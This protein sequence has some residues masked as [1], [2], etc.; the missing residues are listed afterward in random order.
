V[1]TD[2]IAPGDDAALPFGPIP[3]GASRNATVTLTNRGAV[4]PVVVSNMALTYGYHED[5]NDN[6]AQ[7]WRTDEQSAWE[8]SGGA[9][10][11]MP[12]EGGFAAANYLGAT[13]GDFAVQA[14]CWRSGYEAA[15]AGL[16]VRTTPD[17][18]PGVAGSGYLFMITLN[19]YYSVWW[20]D[21][22]AAIP[23]QNWTY[24]GGLST[25]T[26]T[27]TVSARGTTLS[28]FVN[29]TLLWMG[30]DLSYP[31][32]GVALCGYNNGGSTPT[33]HYFD[34]VI[35]GE[36][37]ESGVADGWLNPAFALS[38]TVAFPYAVP[39]GGSIT[40][41]L[42]YRPARTGANA[43][44]LR[45]SSTDAQAPL[46]DVALS[47]SGTASAATIAAARAMGHGAAASIGPLIVLATNNLSAAG[48]SIAAQDDTGGVMLHWASAGDAVAAIAAGL[49]PG[50]A[51]L[52]HG[53][54]VWRSGVYELL[55]PTCFTLLPSALPEA[56]AIDIT[57]LQNHAPTGELCESMLCRIKGVAFDEAG[58]LFAA[59]HDYTVRKAA[60]AG[61]VAINNPADPLAGMPVYTG[62]A[63]IVGILS[64][65]SAT[66]PGTNDTTGYRLLPLGV[67]TPSN[68]FVDITNAGGWVSHDT[69]AI[70]L[71]GTNN[72]IVAGGM[73]WSNAL[74]G[75]GGALAAATA[76]SVPG[77]PLA[78]G[79]N[80]ISMR[81]T[82]AFGEWHEDRVSITRGGAGTGAPF[83]N[84]TNVNAVLS[85]DATSATIGGTNNQHVAGG[86]WWSNSLTK[87]GG[88]FAAGLGWTRAGIALG[89]GANPITVGG[90][91]ALGA[92]ASDLVVLTRGG[93]GTGAPFL[94]VT[95]RV[96]YAPCHAATRALP[97]TN[98]LH[99]AGGMWWSNTTAGA[100]GAVSRAYEGLSFN[101]DAPL[102]YGSNAFAVCGSNLWN[103]TRTDSFIVYRQT[104]AEDQPA[105]ASNAL[106]F[107]AAGSELTESWWT[108][109]IWNAAAVYDLADGAALRLREITL[110]DA[111]SNGLVAV[112]A[113]NLTAGAGACAWAVPPVFDGVTNTYLL[114]FQVVDSSALTNEMLFANNPFT[115]VPE[116]VLLLLA[117][118][119]L[120]ALTMRREGYGTHM[121]AAGRLISASGEKHDEHR[122]DANR[123]T[124]GSRG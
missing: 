56:L 51:V 99:V 40:A 105:I 107:P 49:A 10:R 6:A 91:N 30:S 69:A 36:A 24:H 53:T 80:V 35:V 41:H 59:G 94:L 85:Y 55:N 93:F 12:V 13:F 50:T 7:D 5:F 65:H 60:Q 110:H 64:Q 122:L 66:E 118:A 29:G 124:D 97:G 83:I 3:L 74:A 104:L 61:V 96:I 108:N 43:S 86:M 57:D 111:V 109:I 79:V 22:L 98:T 117:F 115:V 101:A 14:T 33:T 4:Y 82:N 47:G 68:P 120:L 78:V 45:V 46:Q 100:G 37:L 92:R 15:S 119:G 28:F 25:G 71:A 88:V 70:T 123:H 73:A 112:V 81:G 34:D 116:P 89:V 17:F 19:Q 27:L 20:L 87:A 52:A 2:S 48:Y 38:N 11:A 32:G 21:D 9:F 16:A 95:N 23:L 77:V 8:I 18:S 44:R 113:S 84:I 31:T 67:A 1:L 39:P 103:V 54:N 75:A 26:N 114:R 42:A 58:A 62:L 76:W 63:T 72:A 106:I 121:P 102:L 90:T